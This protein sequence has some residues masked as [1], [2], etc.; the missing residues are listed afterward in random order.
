MQTDGWERGFWESGG[1]GVPRGL[2]PPSGAAVAMEGFGKV[3]LFTCP[4]RPGAGLALPVA[5]LLMDDAYRFLT[6]RRA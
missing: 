3:R 4:A 2:C 1:S 6:A 5:V